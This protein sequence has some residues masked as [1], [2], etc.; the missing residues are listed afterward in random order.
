M[1]TKLKSRTRTQFK[2]R[3]CNLKNFVDYLFLLYCRQAADRLLQRSAGPKL[4]FLSSPQD[5]SG[6][7]AQV[8]ETQQ[9]TRDV[10]LLQ[11]L[12]S[13]YY[14]IYSYLR[15]FLDACNIIY[16]DSCVNISQSGGN[17]LYS[18]HDLCY[19][20]ISLHIILCLYYH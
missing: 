18:R 8:W 2:T 11:L 3:P 14:K 17:H 7:K 15:K 19:H 1:S 5:T 6:T 4:Q 16:Q 13:F 9:E 10:V 12:F 20:I